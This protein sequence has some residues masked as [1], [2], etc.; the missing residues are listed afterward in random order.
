MARLNS[1]MARLSMPTFSGEQLLECIKALLRVDADWV[2]AQEG[3]SIYIRPTAIGTSPF[4]GEITCHRRIRNILT[5]TAHQSVRGAGERTCE[6]VCDHVPGG[7]VLQGRLQA[8]EAVR[9]HGPHAGLAGR[10]GQRQGRRKL[11]RSAAAR[12]SRRGETRLL[13]G[14]GGCFFLHRQV[15]VF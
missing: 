4:L 12:A 11:R 1:S 3:Y 5:T 14:A 8:R 15:R 2:P 6:A 10:S 7:P 13:T 9:G